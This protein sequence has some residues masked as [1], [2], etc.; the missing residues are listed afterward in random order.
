VTLAYW[1]LTALSVVVF[2]Y[3]GMSILFANGMAAEFERF[4][5][6]RFRVLTG[7]LELLGALGLI[8][9]QF[10]HGLAIVSA[11]GLTL[12]MALGVITRLR[13]RDTTWQTAPAVV[14]LLVNAFIAWHARGLVRG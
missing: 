9:G 14:L 11:G 6:S 8:A 7:T 4:G 13:V 5:L 10:I 1:A 12:L 3:Y 2:L